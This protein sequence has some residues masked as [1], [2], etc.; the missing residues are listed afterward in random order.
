MKIDPR[1]IQ[2]LEEEAY[3]RHRPDANFR[4]WPA[5]AVASKYRKSGAGFIA[6]RCRGG[7]HPF[8]RPT[9]NRL[10]AGLSIVLGREVSLAEFVVDEDVPGR[11]AAEDIAHGGDVSKAVPPVSPREVGSASR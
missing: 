9:A 2:K 8:S 1:K 7:T 3:G 5:L 4:F 6:T 11:S 10:A